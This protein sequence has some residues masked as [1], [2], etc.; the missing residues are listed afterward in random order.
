MQQ[1]LSDGPHLP[2]ETPA[3]HRSAPGPERVPAPR[4]WTGQSNRS[5]AEKLTGDWRVHDT[6]H[7]QCICSISFWYW[8][9]TRDLKFSSKSRGVYLHVMESSFKTGPTATWWNTCIVPTVISK[10]LPFYLQDVS[11][12]ACFLSPEVQLLSGSA[13]DSC[14]SDTQ[15]VQ[16]RNHCFVWN[17]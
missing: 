6:V 13:S 16:L 11:S 8:Q 4:R 3:P 7:T 1:V 5:Y 17:F 2:H 15:P 10:V 14:C 12:V 9:I